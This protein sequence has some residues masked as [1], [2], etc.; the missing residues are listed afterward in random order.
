[1]VLLLVTLTPPSSLLAQTDET[2]NREARI[3]FET[4][5]SPYCP[6]RTIS[7]CPSPQAD[8]LKTEIK[9]KLASGQAADDIKEELYAS[10]GDDLR[11]VPRA[12]GFG[13]LAWVVPG[14][15]FLAGGWAIAVWMNRTKTPQ[16]TASDPVEIALDPESLARLDAEMNELES[17]T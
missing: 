12:K 2:V 7:N 16:Q 8:V 11:T 1:L 3:I 6:G 17:L 5:M 10:F 13:L 9:E 14:L 4:V 15:G